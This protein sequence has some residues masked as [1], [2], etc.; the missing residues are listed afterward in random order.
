MFSLDWI[1]K[2]QVLNHYNEILYKLVECGEVARNSSFKSLI[3]FGIDNE[4]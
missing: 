3:F 1:G 2:T 4:K